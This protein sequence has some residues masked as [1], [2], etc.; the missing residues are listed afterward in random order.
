[1]EENDGKPVQP[2]SSFTEADWTQ[3]RAEIARWLAD[4][5]PSFVEG[6][7]GAVSL[8]YMPNFPARIHLICHLVRDFY[9]ELPA[10]LGASSS[11]RPGEVFP[12]MAQKL[13]KFWKANPPKQITE[14]EPG[15]LNLQMTATMHSH[16]EKIVQKSI[17][18]ENPT[19]IGTRFAK[20][21][22]QS[23]DRQK[24][25]FIPSWIFKAFDTE[26]DFFVAR[27]HLAKHKDKMPN[28]EGL[29]EHFQSFEKSFHSLIGP[30]FS[31]KEEL[32]AILQD[33][34]TVT[35]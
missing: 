2:A 34:N 13:K 20:V 19:T 28:D 11:P 10:A 32:D 31:G 29:I 26:Y 25:D 17:D 3:E 35:D 18:F 7:T 6:Y 1:M 27:A 23:L 21:L 14:I 5:A 8:L 9:R 16:L 4:R 30:Y 24:E 12:G 33:T 22:Y 15:Y